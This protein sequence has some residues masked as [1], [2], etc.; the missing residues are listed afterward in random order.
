LVEL[1]LLVNK[2]GKFPKYAELG[3]V[4]IGVGEL[5]LPQGE[6][7]RSQPNAQK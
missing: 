3:Q 1:K 2:L 6:G 7:L 4:A 5:P